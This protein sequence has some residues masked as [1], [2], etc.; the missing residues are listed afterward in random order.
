MSQI[1]ADGIAVGDMQTVYKYGLIMLGV[2]LAGSVSSVCVSFFASKTGAAL[3]RDLR[4]DVFLKVSNF[5]NAEFDK[6]RSLRL[7]RELPT[8]LR[9]SRRLRSCFCVW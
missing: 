9:R 5:A 6:F 8:T 7:S 1:V 4:N 3:A 2:A